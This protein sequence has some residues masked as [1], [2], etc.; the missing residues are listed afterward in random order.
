MSALIAGVYDPA[1]PGP[2]PVGSRSSTRNGGHGRT[3]ADSA[4][5]R[6]RG[7]QP[8]M[9]SGIAAPGAAGVGFEPTSDLD[10]HCRFSRQHHFGLVKRALSRLRPRCAPPAASG[11]LHDARLEPWGQ[12]VARCSRLRLRRRFPTPRGST[13]RTS[14]RDGSSPIGRRFSI[15]IRPAPTM[16]GKDQRFESVG[17]LSRFPG[18]FEPNRRSGPFRSG[19]V[20]DRRRTT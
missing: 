18:V 14:S 17:G 2:D 20:E 3:S 5:G 12:T 6:R 9:G 13:G 7:P 10:G 1:A 15:T 4:Q 11:G 19:R 8:R 16:V